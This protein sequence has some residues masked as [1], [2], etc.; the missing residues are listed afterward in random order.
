[1]T[2]RRFASPLAAG[3]RA[4]AAALVLLLALAATAG[5]GGDDDS[6]SPATTPNVETRGTTDA[7]VTETGTGEATAAAGR[8]VFR[9]NCAGCHTMADADA[10][11]QVGP[12]LDQAQPSRELVEERVRNGSGV[13]PS[14]E[15][16][17]SDPEIDSV[18]AY[19]ASAAGG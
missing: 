17:L 7:T 10:S 6:S 13:M 3:L 8:E 1:M 15:E 4:A 14:F 19:V 18:V 11:G 12:N 16:Q 9:A 5:C 2:S